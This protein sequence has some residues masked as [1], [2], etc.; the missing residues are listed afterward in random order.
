MKAT[1]EQILLMVEQG[2]DIH[3]IMAEFGYKSDSH[4]YTVCKKHGVKLKAVQNRRD[5]VVEMRKSGM[6]MAEIASALGMTEVN[7]GSICKRYGMGRGYV[8]PHTEMSVCKECGCMFIKPVNRKDQEF[9]S[10]EC[11][12]AHSHRIHDPKRRARKRNCSE[13]EEIDIKDVA[14][15]DHGICYLCGE[16]VDWNDYTYSNGKKVVHRN[17]PSVDHVIPLIKGGAHAMSNVR[18]AHLGC[19]SSKG[20]KDADELHS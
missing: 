14:K 4:I 2:I 9:C 3:S 16:P 17:Y 7:V 5:K 18:L 12:K 15:R 13:C 20:T 1:D 6:L 11:R 8:K 10:D 19:N